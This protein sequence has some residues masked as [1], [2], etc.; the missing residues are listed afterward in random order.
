[1]ETHVDALSVV[2][3]LVLLGFCQGRHGGGIKVAPTD[4]EVPMERTAASEYR[5]MLVVEGLFV[6]LAS[7]ERS[8]LL[9]AFLQRPDQC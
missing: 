9:T 4:D 3:L 6:Q 8:T 2:R 7:T 5:D 1:M